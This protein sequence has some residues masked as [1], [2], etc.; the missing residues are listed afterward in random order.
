MQQSTTI[1]IRPH[2]INPAL[3]APADNATIYYYSTPPMTTND[4]DDDDEANIT[5]VHYAYLVGAFY[6]K[7]LWSQSDVLFK[8]RMHSALM[9]F[10]FS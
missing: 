6:N 1:L 4:Y 2:I 9:S 7:L 8:Y 3:P 5:T 10:Q